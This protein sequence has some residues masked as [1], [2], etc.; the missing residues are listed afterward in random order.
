MTRPALGSPELERMTREW[1]AAHD[2]APRRATRDTGP[3]VEWQ[4]TPVSVPD[5]DDGVLSD[6]DNSDAAE[7]ASTF[8]DLSGGRLVVALSAWAWRQDAQADEHRSYMREVRTTDPLRARRWRE[9]EARLRAD[10]VRGTQLRRKDKSRKHWERREH[11][12]A[13]LL[14]GVE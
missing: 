3:V 5:T 14:P 1:L 2:P 12:A 6:S 10:P 9:C 13:G 7:I 4:V 11:K 8:A